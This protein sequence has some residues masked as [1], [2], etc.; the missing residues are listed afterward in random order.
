MLSNNQGKKIHEAVDNY[1]VF[2][3]ETTGISPKKD[4]VIEIS[5][6]KVTGGKVVD[7][8]SSLVNPHRPIPYHASMVNGITDDMVKDAPDFCEVL[9]AFDEFIEDYVLVG[10]N[11]YSFDMK[12]I[13]RDSREYFGRIIGNDFIDTLTLSRKCLPELDHHRLTDL[14]DYYGISTKGAHRALND[15]IMNQLVYEKLKEKIV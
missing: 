10:H 3:L 1:V 8:F 6:V 4:S 14:A 9:K 13:C 11:I 5:A 2:D 7:E 12:F 15:C